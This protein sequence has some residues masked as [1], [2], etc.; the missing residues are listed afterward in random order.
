MWIIFMKYDTI[1]VFVSLKIEDLFQSCEKYLPPSWYMS[2]PVILA[3]LMLLQ[4]LS[5]S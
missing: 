2:E 4:V 3:A 5:F 1:F